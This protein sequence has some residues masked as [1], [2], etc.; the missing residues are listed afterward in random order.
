M[1]LIFLQEPLQTANSYHFL[2]SLEARQEPEL[3]LLSTE[4]VPWGAIE[5]SYVTVTEFSLWHTKFKYISHI[6]FEFIALP[7]TFQT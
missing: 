5:K 7:R 3:P 2:L 1:V 6:L 4:T